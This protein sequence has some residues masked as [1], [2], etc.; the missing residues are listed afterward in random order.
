M[1]ELEY[2]L[3][4]IPHPEGYYFVYCMHTCLLEGFVPTMLNAI[5]LIEDFELMW[6]I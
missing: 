2:T 6:K 1:K 4:I 3:P 5:N